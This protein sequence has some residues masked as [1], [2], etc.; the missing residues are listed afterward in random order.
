MWLEDSKATVCSKIL[1]YQP[2]QCETYTTTC[3]WLIQYILL[4]VFWVE[5]DSHW[6]HLP[7]QS[8][9][10]TADG[11]SQ[12]SQTMLSATGLSLQ[13]SLTALPCFIK[14]ISGHHGQ[15]R[16][17][18]I[19]LFKLVECSWISAAHFAC[20]S[21]QFYGV[22]EIYLACIIVCIAHVPYTLTGWGE[23]SVKHMPCCIHTGH[24]TCHLSLLSH[25]PLRT[26]SLKHLIQTPH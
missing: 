16:G 13:H 26:E 9:G 6:C 5:S 15:F 23:L 8:Y 11:V 17:N 1:G 21:G 22:L 18:P 14:L 24:S 12:S 4:K 20:L 19:S 2:C 3:T 10:R 25:H 7:A